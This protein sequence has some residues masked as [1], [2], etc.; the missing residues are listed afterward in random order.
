MTGE[1]VREPRE[2]GPCARTRPVPNRSG[3]GS[4][5]SEAVFG[6]RASSLFRE[7]GRVGLL[8]YATLT[9]RSEAGLGLC[10]DPLSEIV[11]VAAGKGYR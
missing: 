5:L 4:P 11:P 7:P 8:D 6:P 10:V 2:N 9:A 1:F 3:V